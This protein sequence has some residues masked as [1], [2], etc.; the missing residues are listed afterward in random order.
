[1]GLIKKE[2]TGSRGAERLPRMM[3]S[4]QLDHFSNANLENNG[5]NETDFEIRSGV[6]IKLSQPFGK[7][8]RLNFEK[9]NNN[10]DSWLSRSPIA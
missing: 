4:L 3:S 1:M 10:L 5:V 6:I 9:V 7:S 8:V 2:N